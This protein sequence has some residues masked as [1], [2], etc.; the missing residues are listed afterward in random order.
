MLQIVQL[1]NEMKG[2]GKSKAQVKREIDKT[3]TLVRSS[4]MVSVSNKKK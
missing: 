4:V 3:I 1:Q 2:K